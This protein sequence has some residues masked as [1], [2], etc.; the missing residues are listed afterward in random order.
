MGGNMNIVVL[1]GYTLRAGM[2]EPWP[3][4]GADNWTVYDRTPESLVAERAAEAEILVV[5]KAVVDAALMD[6]LPR[7]RCIAVTAAGTNIVDLQAAGERGIPVCNTPAYG[8]DAV[9]QHVFALLLELCRHTALHDASVR[10]GDWARCEDFCYAL[11]PQVE[12]TGRTLGIFGFGNLGRRVAEIGHAFGMKVLACAHRPVPAPDYE[13]FE[14]VSREE[15]FRRSD[16]LSL[17]CPLTEE[18]RGLVCRET[19]DLMKPGSI[20]INTARGPVVRG[21]DVAEALREGRLGGF[22]A[23]VLESEPP[24]EDDPLLSAPHSLI[25]PHIAWMTDGARRNIISITLENI[26]R[27][28]EGNPQNVVNRA[29]LKAQR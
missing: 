24:S 23:D 9:A 2:E 15:L 13:P 5:N 29:W 26:R 8:T 3:M 19:L 14:F 17:H 10:R 18:T 7:L 11:T 12:L 20:I 25:T 1:D 22:G 28:K 6:A 27:F 21:A 16:V 4:N